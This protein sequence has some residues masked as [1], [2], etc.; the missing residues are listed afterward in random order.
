MAEDVERERVL[1]AYHTRGHP[2]AYSAPAVV[3][4][5]HGIP[6]ARAR[7]DLEHSQS[8]TLHREYKRP[9]QNNPYYVHNM[10]YRRT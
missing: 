7:R 5:Y 10:R 9:R 3:T 6:V 4:R 8:Y 2:T 1:Q